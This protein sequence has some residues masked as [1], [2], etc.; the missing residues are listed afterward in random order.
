[1]T[2]WISVKDGLP[3]ENSIILI[4]NSDKEVMI[5]EYGNSLEGYR[6]YTTNF[7]Q[8]LLPGIVTHWMTLPAPPGS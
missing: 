5:G 4:C 6:F 8:Y 1:M 2:K 7:E 3:D